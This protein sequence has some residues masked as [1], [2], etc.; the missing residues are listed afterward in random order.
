MRC[1]RITVFSLLLALTCPVL[2]AAKLDPQKI[3]SPT[4]FDNAADIR[5][6]TDVADGQAGYVHYF[7]ITHPDGTP[8]DQVGIELEDRRIA[9]SFPGAGVIVSGFVKEGALDI[10]GRTFFIEHLHGIRPFRT[11]G[12]MQALR[13]DLARRVAYW[14]DEETPYCIF[15]QPG[16]KLC[17][18]CGDFV[19]RILFPATNALMVG[20]PEEFTRTL[21]NMP[22]TDDLLIYMLGL[23]N[24]PDAKSRL[25]RLATL[26][27]PSSLRLDVVE[28]LQPD[29]TL[30][31]AAP[32][33]TTAGLAPAR[34]PFSR[35]ATRRTQSR[36]L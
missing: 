18:N 15:R 5:A 25:E 28:M 21:G 7:L 8:E 6:V 32:G 31:A 36:R 2:Q 16:G 12:E 10:A 29:Q 17:L 20:L 30:Q 19:A 33:V 22:S 3:S 27:L 1:P 35:I 14:V 11:A 24:L 23:H 9:W 34:K 26:D 13:N 4:A